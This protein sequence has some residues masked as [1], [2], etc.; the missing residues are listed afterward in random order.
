MDPSGWIAAISALLALAALYFTSQQTASARQQT[1]LQQQM[2]EDQAQPYVWADI[3]PN[4]ES[5]HLMMLVV[6][7]E[8]PTTATDVSVAFDPP[9]PREIGGSGSSSEYR[10]VGMPP[11]RTMRWH[12]NLAPDWLNGASAKRFKVTVRSSGPFGAVLPIAYELDVDEYRRASATPPGTI[13]GITKQLK[14]L[15]ESVRSLK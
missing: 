2:R 14:K 4:D 8:G 6:H 9:L 13:N 5:M 10:I 7:N 3:R 15:N 1:A 12:L 11:G